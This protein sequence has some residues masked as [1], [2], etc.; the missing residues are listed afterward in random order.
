MY[1]FLTDTKL[2]TFLLLVMVLKRRD[3]IEKFVNKCSFCRNLNIFYN[4]LSAESQYL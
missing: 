4:I 2:K 3:L 1:G